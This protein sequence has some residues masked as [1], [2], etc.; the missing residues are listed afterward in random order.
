M[1]NT[2]QIISKSKQHIWHPCTQMKDLEC[3]PPLVIHK[4]QGGYLYTDRGVIFDA[5]SSWWCKSLGHGHP[6]VVAAITRQ[7]QKFEHIMGADTTHPLLVELG[8]KLAEISGNQHVFF[9]SDGSS[10]VEI[11]LKMA[12][13][14]KELQGKGHCREF[15]ALQNSYHGETLG[16]LGVSDLGLYKQPYSG[17]NMAC[18]FI[19]DLPYVTDASDPLWHDASVYWQKALP[20]LEMWKERCCAII[21]EPIVQGA[22]G[23][24][25][26]SADFL[27]RL[28]FWAKS[29]DIIFIA[30]EIMTGMCRTGKW[31]ASQYA[32]IKADLIC[33]S[34]GLTSGTI[35]LSCVLIDNAIY[36]L[37]YDDYENGRSFLHSHTYSGHALGVSAALATITTMADQHINDQANRLGQTMYSLLKEVST[38]SGRLTNVR[39]IGAIVAADLQKSDHKRLGYLF[40]QEALSQGAL[41]RP[42]GNTLYWLPPL[43]SD[44]DSIVKL[45][46][47]TLNSLKAVYR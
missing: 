19:E 20:K 45:A 2:A 35:P 27:K 23:M 24:L 30:D 34:K 7:L 29:N 46:E 12:W 13:H 16:T 37:F 40:Y 10:A 21:V 39:N 6:A 32:G 1:V 14:A 15:I 47:I 43:N 26:Y 5:I 17:F 4:A 44:V 9:A 3:Y 22:G 31:L 28:A 18:H 11:A 33:L 8:E 41:I 36:E 38:A 42:L 25:F